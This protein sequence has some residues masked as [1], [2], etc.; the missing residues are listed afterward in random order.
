MIPK[1]CR[2]DRA[3]FRPG[4]PAEDTPS[5]HAGLRRARRPRLPRSGTGFQPVG[6]GRRR[7]GLQPA[8][9]GQKKGGPSRDPKE[10]GSFG[11]SVQ[12]GVTGSAAYTPA[13]E[14]PTAAREGGRGRGE[15][16]PCE[17][18]SRR[19][20]DFPVT[21]ARRRFSSRRTTTG[22]GAVDTHD[23]P[24]SRCS[25]PADLGF[26]AA[27]PGDDDRSPPGR[28]RGGTEDTPGTARFDQGPRDRGGRSF[29]PGCGPAG[30]LEASRSGAISTRGGGDTAFPARVGGSSA[31]RGTKAASPS[32]SDASPRAAA[33]ARPAAPGPGA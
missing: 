23:V 7:L 27:R 32:R 5:L 1:P 18:G 13:R 22:K 25:W 9:R 29:A 6:P 31:P 19:R 28:G 14:Y 30:A 33:P 15:I 17:A 12:Y 21:S 2:E 26:Q 4:G 8:P 16:R 24:V 3:C 11:L 10:V 20:P